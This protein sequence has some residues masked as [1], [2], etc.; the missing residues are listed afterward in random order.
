MGFYGLSRLNHGLDSI[1]S[2]PEIPAAQVVF[3]L[4]LRLRVEILKGKAD[5]VGLGGFQIAFGD[6]E[7]GEGLLLIA[8]EVAGIL[9]PD[10]A[11]LG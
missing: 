2:G 5:P 11:R 3:S 7:P 4:F 10:V 1:M 9:E 6:V 8:G